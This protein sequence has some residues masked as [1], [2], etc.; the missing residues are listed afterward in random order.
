[1]ISSSPG[2]SAASPQR[3]NAKATSSTR[4]RLIHIL[5]LFMRSVSYE[6]PA[7]L[8]S[9]ENARGSDGS[10]IGSIFFVPPFSSL[11]K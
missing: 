9:A 8:A 11:Q 1:M 6:H 3:R 5:I 4:A 7:A 10:K 2:D